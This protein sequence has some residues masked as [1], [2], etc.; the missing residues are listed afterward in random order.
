MCLQETLGRSTS[1]AN[2]TARTL[3]R[4]KLEALVVTWGCTCT[5]ADGARGHKHNHCQRRYS[6]SPDTPRVHVRG[7]WHLATL[8]SESHSLP[9]AS[10]MCCSVDPSTAST[11]PAAS[12]RMLLPCT[13]SLLRN[14]CRFARA[15]VIRNVPMT[16]VANAFK[17]Q[18]QN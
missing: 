6:T 10:P 17:H 13:S 8:T 7:L 18:A 11:M 2:S 4:A 16:N 14:L 5:C 15:A 12:S 9:K 1:D 3:G